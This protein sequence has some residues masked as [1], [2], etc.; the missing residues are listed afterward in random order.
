MRKKIKISLMLTLV[1]ALLFVS[2]SVYGQVKPE[3]LKNC[4]NGAFSTE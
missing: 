1:M 3:T 4:I 2:S